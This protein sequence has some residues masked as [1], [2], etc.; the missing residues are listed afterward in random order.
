MTNFTAENND[1]A[2]RSDEI[3]VWANGE[4]AIFRSV[5]RAQSEAIRAQRWATDV[6]AVDVNGDRV[7]LSASERSPWTH[8]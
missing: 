2:L 8:Q 1:R 6:H 3:Q 5:E 7:D 4:S